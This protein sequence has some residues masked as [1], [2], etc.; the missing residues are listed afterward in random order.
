MT[1]SE[2]TRLSRPTI[3][4]IVAFVGG[5][6]IMAAVAALLVN[7]QQR[8]AEAVEYPLRVVSVARRAGPRR[9]GPELSPPVRHAS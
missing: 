8:K 3:L 1:S 9:L 6:L 2:K 4:L 7:I 5:M